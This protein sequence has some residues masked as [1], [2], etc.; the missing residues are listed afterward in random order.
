MVSADESQIR[1]RVR[2]DDACAWIDAWAAPLAPEEIALADAAGRILAADIEAAIDLP[3]LDRAAVDGY[4]LQADET[5]GAGAYNPL[6]LRLAPASARAGAGH[7]VA[8]HSGDPLP[9]G[10]DA[11]VRLEHALPDAPGTVAV[12]AS[13]YAGNEVEHHAS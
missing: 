8:V 11:V 13:V 1:G 6:T 7:A 3:P 2:L 4:A 10:A 5:V 12:I 9:P